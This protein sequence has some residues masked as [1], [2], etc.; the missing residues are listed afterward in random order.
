MYLKRRKICF[1]QFYDC[2]GIS[3]HIIT[4]LLDHLDALKLYENHRENGIL[5]VMLVDGHGSR[6]DLFLNTYNLQSAKSILGF[7]RD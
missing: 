7:E 4:N 5:P 1:V 6:F 2:E 3:G